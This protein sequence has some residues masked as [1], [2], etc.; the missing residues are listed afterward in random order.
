MDLIGE[1]EAAE[2]DDY[3][4]GETGGEGDGV[5]ARVDATNTR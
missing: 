1:Y 3:L 5:D 4:T 2:R